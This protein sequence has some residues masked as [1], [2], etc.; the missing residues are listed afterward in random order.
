M[1]KCNP[2]G[3]RCE[4]GRGLVEAIHRAA[5]TYYMRACLPGVEMSEL[6]ALHTSL[7]AAH[8]AYAQHVHPTSEEVKQA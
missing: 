7:V 5:R 2:F 3:S 6:H 1:C 4:T 8:D